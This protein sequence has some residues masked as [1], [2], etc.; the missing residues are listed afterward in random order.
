MLYD[1]IKV[2]YDDFIFE[3][4]ELA[5]N[6]KKDIVIFGKNGS[7]KSTLSKKLA[8]N[9]LEEIEYNSHCQFLSGE[10]PVSPAQ[11][12]DLKI[13][14]YNSEFQNKYVS[15]SESNDFE[16]IVM[17]GNHKLYQNDLDMNE[18]EKN[19]L[20]QKIEEC[21]SQI[22]LIN[23]EKEEE[24]LKKEFKEDNKWA[25]RQRRIY[26]NKKNTS[27]NLN[28]IEKI[29]RTSYKQSK[30]IA[31]KKLWNYIC[32]I[33]SSRKDSMINK[34]S[35]LN[36]ISETI[37][38]IDF[39]LTETDIIN[40]FVSPDLLTRI[41]KIGETIINPTPY[42]E[43]EKR[44][45][46]VLKEFGPE[47]LDESIEMTKSRKDYCPTCYSELSNHLKNELSD[48]INRVI[49]ESNTRT[50]E[51]EIES[52]RFNKLKCIQPNENLDISN[53]NNLNNEIEEYKN[54]TNNII[55]I[56]Q[57]KKRKLYEEV[58]LDD[59]LLKLKKIISQIISS[60]KLLIKNIDDYNS[61]F[62][63]RKMLIDEATELNANLAYYETSYKF[64]EFE[65]KKR[66]YNDFKRKLIRL[67]EEKQEVE[68]KIN[69]L[70]IKM[71]QTDIA[72][73]EI[74]LN[75]AQIFY[76][77]NRL[78]LEHADD[79]YYVK[80]R[81]K[82]VQLNDLSVGE[83]NIIGL[84]YFFSII[85]KNKSTYDLFSDKLLVVL[86][87]PISS[88]DRENKLG[89]YNLLSNYFRKIESGN[90]DSKIIVLTHDME[91][92]LN[93]EKIL[94]NLPNNKKTNS[95]IL[96]REG[97][98]I[99]NNNF[100]HQYTKNI[101]DI[102]SFACG[103]RDD[104]KDVIGNVMRKVF[105][106]FSTFNYQC[107]LDELLS[108]DSIM[109]KI[110]SVQER[111]FF[112]NFMFRLVFHNESHMLD[113]TKNMTDLNHYS[114][115]TKEE[116]MYTAKMMIVLLYKLNQDHVCAYINNLKKEGFII[117]WTNQ[118]ND[119]SILSKR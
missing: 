104:L 66:L 34:V 97:L 24:E 29:H 25:D 88:F 82:T 4:L 79:K 57:N 1:T 119:F 101:N 53:Q 45:L 99:A 84:C 21:N 78:V 108:K 93:I 64:G 8:S 91:V 20:I 3:N 90:N 44:I 39:N 77:K 67:E 11:L 118:I 16:A 116:K 6:N 30:D 65:D 7:G 10:N 62:E 32:D 31:E 9:N 75:L 112:Q 12:K 113:V 13:H 38:K 47:K 60:I 42:N 98:Q 51:T 109:K 102:Y 40:E 15:F 87:D 54:Q 89:V 33:E 74:N 96:D 86:D 35:L 92:F 95:M 107:G 19:K 111:E 18:N 36:E 110:E 52:V 94:H 71:K 46:E 81:G 68:Q 72:L 105:E 69:S 61:R 83:Q 14:V 50:L 114:Y 58:Y 43:R 106:A 2:F 117:E 41:K 70:I 23:I 56:L 49:E 59:E 48:S 85:N 5:F 28:K 80:S 22:K 55:R 73:N 17:L 76:D 26:G 115:L 27:V 100:K 103:K 37:V 63:K